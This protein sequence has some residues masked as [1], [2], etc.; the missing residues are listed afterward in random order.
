MI[1]SEVID[2]IEFNISTKDD[3]SGKSAN[4]LFTKRNIVRALKT[5]LDDYAQ[6]TLEIEGIKS[7]SISEDQRMPLCGK[8]KSIFIP[9]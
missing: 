2:R 5:A 3:L 4:N 8:I 9:E 7:Y 6:Y 1:V